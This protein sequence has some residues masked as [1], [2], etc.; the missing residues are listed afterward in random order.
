M[1]L[2][3]IIV[4]Y[5]S[6]NKLVNCLDSIGGAELNG[7]DYEIIVVDNN[8]GDNLSNLESDYSR[9]ELI[10]SQKNLGMGEGNNLGIANSSGKIILI[11]NPDT[12]IKNNAIPVLLDYLENNHDVGVVGPKLTYADGSL[13][14]SCARF[15]KVYM[16][17][18]RRTFL[19]EYFKNI[20]DRFTMNDFNHESTGEVDWLMGSCLM[21]RRRIVLPDGSIFEPR[22]DKRYFMYFED[23]D[24]C[25]QVWTKGLKV[26]YNPR[27]IIVHDHARES[28]KYPWYLAVFLDRLARHHI[29]SWITYFIKWGIK[30]NDN[31][32]EKN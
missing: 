28:A 12:V 13:Q 31:T 14:H 24:L 11:L 10:N 30:F 22:F 16:P 17:I 4:N 6:K 23:I 9:V 7:L 2:S 26:I 18:L 8:S 29:S 21:F 19:G 5:K 1:D 3:I 25:R 27:A 32:Y 20:R 15:P